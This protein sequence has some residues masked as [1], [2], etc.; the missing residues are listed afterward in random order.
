M[1]I[2][3]RRDGRIC[4]LV[5][6]WRTEPQPLLAATFGTTASPSN[7]LQTS[8]D[9]TSRLKPGNYLRLE[10]VPVATLIFVK[11]I[12]ATSIRMGSPDVDPDG[13]RAD[14]VIT[15]PAG[16]SGRKW[17]IIELGEADESGISIKWEEKTAPIKFASQGETEANH[18]TSGMDWSFTVPM[19]EATMERIEAVAARAAISTRNTEGEPV[20]MGF[21]NPVGFDHKRNSRQLSFICRG[22]GRALSLDPRDR[23]DF[24][25]ANF[26]FSSDQKRG[27]TSQLVVPLEGRAYPDKTR[28][29]NGYPTIAAI[30]PDNLAFDPAA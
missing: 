16:T 8:A 14:L 17:E 19:A 28:L 26:K 30:N 21:V 22:E 12:S 20:A 2:F 23:F 29:L 24:F 1:N 9:L 10:T 3:G 7:S 18:F 15:V 5:G 11:D 4:P 27:A 13:I 25:R 6:F